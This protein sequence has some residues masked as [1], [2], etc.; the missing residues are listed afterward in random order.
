MIRLSVEMSHHLRPLLQVSRHILSVVSIDFLEARAPPCFKGATGK[1]VLYTSKWLGTNQCKPQHNCAS[2]CRGE[3]VP[4][5]VHLRA[6]SCA[7]CAHCACGVTAQTESL[8]VRCSTPAANCSSA[9][10]ARQACRP[11]AQLRMPGM[12]LLLLRTETAV[13]QSAPLCKQAGS[14]S[15]SHSRRQRRRRS[16]CRRGAA[17]SVPQLQGGTQ[18]FLRDRRCCRSIAR[19]S[20]RR[21][22]R[23]A[24]RQAAHAVA[25]L[26]AAPWR[27]HAGALLNG[28]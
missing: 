18:Q 11:P 5:T 12:P 26:S 14:C 22:G 17:Q 8:Y 3:L 10:N 19:R 27:L 16:S 23:C 28:C 9:H 4:T 7:E 6:G 15:T 1:P 2:D 24:I 20:A 13:G 25:G 21:A